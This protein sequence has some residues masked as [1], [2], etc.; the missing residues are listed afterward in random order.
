MDVDNIIAA[1][2]VLVVGIAVEVDRRSADAAATAIVIVADGPESSTDGATPGPR[3]A[4]VVVVGS[5]VGDEQVSCVERRIRYGC[6]A[7]C[8]G[9][10]TDRIRVVEN[11]AC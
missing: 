10:L 11:G 5:V 8:R 3:R 9:R 4:A 6:R 7:H 2:P 1:Q